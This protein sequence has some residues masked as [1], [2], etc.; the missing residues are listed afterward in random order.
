MVTCGVAVSAPT[1]RQIRGIV[2]PRPA[3]AA[4]VPRARVSVDGTRSDQ[5]WQQRLA[6]VLIRSDPVRSHPPNCRAMG[7]ESR[8]QPLLFRYGKL[9][10]ILPSW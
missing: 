8:S 9:R 4:T 2:V 3:A 1:P 6:S 10:T 7:A 5:L